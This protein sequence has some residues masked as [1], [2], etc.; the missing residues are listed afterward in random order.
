MQLLANTTSPFVRIARIAMLEKGLDVEPTIVDPWA[1]DA[2]LRAANTAARVPT[3]VLDDGTALSECLLI[4]QWLEATQ[5]GPSVLGS[6]PAQ[7][8]GVLSR[9]GIAIGAIEASTITII[10]RKA[11][12]PVRS[13]AV[14]PPKPNPVQRAARAVRDLLPAAR[15]RAPRPSTPEEP[16]EA[17]TAPVV[18]RAPARQTPAHKV[19]VVRSDGIGTGVPKL[20]TSKPAALP[21]PAVQRATDSVPT[22]DAG[23]PPVRPD[24][25]RPAPVITPA[26]VEPPVVLPS[27]PAAPAPTQGQNAPEPVVRRPSEPRAESAT[28]RASVRPTA[29]PP[30]QPVQRSSN[31]VTPPSTLSSTVDKPTSTT[32]PADRA[33]VNRSS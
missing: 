11:T 29:Q 21:G 25:P 15:P 26:P 9:A 20:R 1:D 17:R 16:A 5:P 10:T 3:L 23:T 18:Q 27:E 4:V 8:A 7:V 22:T 14:A 6:G 33:A 32:R 31:P 19:P 24:P 12:A 28:G 2:R 30:S 13:A